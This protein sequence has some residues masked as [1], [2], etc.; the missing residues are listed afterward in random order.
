MICAPAIQAAAFKNCCMD[1]GN[2]DGAQR[3]Y[4]F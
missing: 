2:Y 4:F 3:D 1:R